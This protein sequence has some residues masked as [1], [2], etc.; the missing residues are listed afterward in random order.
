[1][2][3]RKQQSAPVERQTVAVRYRIIPYFAVEV[4]DDPQFS[5]TRGVG[6]SPFDALVNIRGRV[7]AVYPAKGFDIQ[8][9]IVNPEFIEGW[10]MPELNR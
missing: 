8:E 6:A 9:S 10:R 7:R 4:A 5:G 1:M 3:P 2:A